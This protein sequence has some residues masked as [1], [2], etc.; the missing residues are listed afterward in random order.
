MEDKIKQITEWVESKGYT[1]PDL[2]VNAII[3]C[4]NDLGL[5]N[6]WVRVD[7]ITLSEG[8][9]WLCNLNGQL[10]VLELGY[11][12]PTHE[13]NF[14]P[15]FYWY[16]PYNDILIIEWHEITRVHPLPPNEGE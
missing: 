15:Y 13:E 5:S 4:F 2:V 12:T 7:S 8:D 1:R 11:E 3:N 10:I 6:E 14:K 9:R 16:E